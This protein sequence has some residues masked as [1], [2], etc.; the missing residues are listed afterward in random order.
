[1]GVISY[2]VKEGHY[3]GWPALLSSFWLLLATMTPIIMNGCSSR[4]SSLAYKSDTPFHIH[5][6]KY[7]CYKYSKRVE[8]LTKY[9][10]DSVSLNFNSFTATQI[11]REINF[12]DVFWACKFWNDSFWCSQNKGHSWFHVKSEIQE[13]SFLLSVLF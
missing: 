7:G 12:A 1:M 13:N 5:L 11:L 4:R 10:I 9:W 6:Y 3:N 2:L 8:L